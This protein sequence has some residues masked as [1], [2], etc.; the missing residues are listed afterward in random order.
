MSSIAVAIVEDNADLLDDLVLNL[1]WRGIVPT[2][3]LNGAAFNAALR[4]GRSWQVLVLDLGLPGEDGLSI[5]RRLRESNPQ[6]GIIM[7]TAHGSIADRIQGLTDGADIYLVKPADMGEL[8]AAIKSVARRIPETGSASPAWR[9]DTVGIRL[10]DPNGKATDL[11]YSEF[12][13]VRALAQSPDHFCETD[14][15]VVAIGKDPRVYDSRALQVLLSRLRL[16][17]GDESPLKAVR[18][19]GYIFA[20]KLTLVSAR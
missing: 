8:A 19:K 2:P 20:A 16:K 7:L 13:L 15:L 5:A 17:L 10:I 1:S 6:M 18:A 4:D 11:S 3:F 12:A 14:T 9:V